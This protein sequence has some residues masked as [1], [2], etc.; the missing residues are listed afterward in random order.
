M[1]QLDPLRLDD[2]AL[3]LRP[4]RANDDAAVGG[5]VRA[6]EGVR[7]VRRET[8]QTVTSSS[9]RWIPATGIGTQSGRLSSS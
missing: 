3:R 1:L 6:E 4:Q 5:R 2:D 8:A 7:V 9:R